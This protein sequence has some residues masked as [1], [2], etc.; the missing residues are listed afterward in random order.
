[1]VKKDAVLSKEVDGFTINILRD[2]SPESPRTWDNVG[3]LMTFHR[4]CEIQD[5][6]EFKNSDAFK[7]YLRSHE[8]SL[9]I[10]PV[11]A[12]IHSGVA[13]SLT[14][15]V[16]PFNDRWDACQ[17]G[18]IYCTKKKAR[19]E[20]GN[21][22]AQK[23]DKCFQG[24][25]ENMNRYLSGEVYGYAVT[26]EADDCVESCWGFYCTPEEVMK[27]VLSNIPKKKKASKKKA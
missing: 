4:D 21:K 1:M 19:A 27:E 9:I 8:K 18:V 6:K 22:Y 5:S 2:D 7:E 25:I 14:N 12:Y 13:L 15:T 17:I 16:Y 23:I 3:T 10:R 11:F 24:E 26:D 20:L